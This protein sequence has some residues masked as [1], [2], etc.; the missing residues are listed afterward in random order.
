MS[1][2]DVRN[3]GQNVGFRPHELLAGALGSC[4]SIW[5][6]K[7]AHDHGLAVEFVSV[8][9]ELDR[10]SPDEVVFK[11]SISINGDLT[12]EER[13]RLYRV[14][15]TCPLQKTLGKKLTFEVECR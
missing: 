15:E 1:D 11:K 4:I 8:D 6:R 10:S 9:I 5:V 13:K 3:G 7:Y 14:A 12:E 2:T